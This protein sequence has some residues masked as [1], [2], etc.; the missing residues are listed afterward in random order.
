MFLDDILIFSRSW[1]DHLLH[2]DEVLSVLEKEQLF[3]KVA[4]CEFAATIVKFLG[5]IISG[6]TIGPDPDKLKAVKDWCKPTSVKDIRRFLG[7]ANYF[8]RFI[9]DYARIARPLEELTGKYTQFIW[10][11]RQQ[12]AFDRL[13]EALMCAP[14]LQLADVSRKFHVMTDASD[15]SIGGVLLQQD[16]HEFWHPIAYT[17]RRLR[18]EERNY[19]ASERETLAVIHALRVWKLYLFKPF[20]LITDNQCVKYLQTKPHLS[21]REARWVEFLADFDVTVLHCPGKENMADAISRSVEL[22]ACSAEVVLSPE[23]SFH[24]QLSSGYKSDRT[25]KSIITRLQQNDQHLRSRF[26]WDSTLKCL[27]LLDEPLDRLCIP[28][29][30]LRRQLIFLSH[31]TASA[32][33]SGRDKTYSRLARGFYWPRMMTEVAKYVKTC[34]TCHVC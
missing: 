16:S 1:Q 17:S 27:Y 32:S 12:K 20:D 31:D 6:E 7:F 15:E 33:H 19:T 24:E 23:A 29:G 8:R 25:F 13:R 10:G 2:L 11:S 3:C 30:P 14:V 4:K 18:P 22:K 28:S 9:K 5:H 34:R 26:R 21:K